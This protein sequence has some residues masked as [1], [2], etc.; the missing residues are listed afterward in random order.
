VYRRRTVPR[1]SPLNPHPSSPA[2]LQARIQAERDGLPF[3][4]LRDGA[5]T[6]RV[7]RLAAAAERL[8]IGRGEGVDVALDWDD[9]VSRVHAELERVGDAWAL[10]DDGLS[11]NGSFVNGKRLRGRRRLDDADELRFGGTRLLYRSPGRGGAASPPL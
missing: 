4:L 8:T 2:E 7:V 11:R 1:S 3:L 5:G 10:V 6:H 9:R